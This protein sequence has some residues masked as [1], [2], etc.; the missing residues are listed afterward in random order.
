[1]QLNDPVTSVVKDPDT[2]AEIVTPSKTSAARGVETENPLPATVTVAPMGPCEG[3]TVIATVVT[4]NAPIALWPP[5]SVAVTVV[6]DVPPGTLNEQLNAPVAPV[7]RDP[8]EQLA[9]VTPSNTREASGLDT[10]KPVPATVTAEPVG[11]WPGVTV[12]AGTVT[13]NEP[14]ATRP[15]ESVAET[16]VPDVP[17]GTAKVQLQAP[18]GLVDSDPLEQVEIATPSKTSDETVVDPENPVPETVT[19]APIGPWPGLTTI[20]GTLKT[21]VCPTEDPETVTP[22]EDGFATYPETGPT[23]NV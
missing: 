9:T 3:V 23:L 5:T 18:V 16:V 6:P 15:P 21:I 11:P 12:I 22:P 14:S 19:V 20:D 7:V 8:D 1:M 2:H 13:L 17:L 10:E 4:V